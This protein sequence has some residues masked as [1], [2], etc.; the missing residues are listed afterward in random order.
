MLNDYQN[1]V[2][3]GITAE[4]EVI[5]NHFCYFGPVPETLY[6]QIKD[7]KWRSALRLASRVADEKVE[8]QPNLRLRVWGEELGEMAL[9]ML[10]GMTNLDPTARVTIDQV[11]AHPYWREGAS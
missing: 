3:A 1:L 4:Q 9:D 8:E 7:E 11:L 2:K 6:Q 10:S 5:T